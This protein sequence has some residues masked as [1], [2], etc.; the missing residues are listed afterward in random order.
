MPFTSLDPS[1]MGPNPDR[2]VTWVYL[3]GGKVRAFTFL[4]HQALG[5]NNPSTLIVYTPPN[6]DVLMQL[7]QVSST[8]ARLASQIQWSAM[9]STLVLGPCQRWYL[10]VVREQREAA[11]VAVT[12][13]TYLKRYSKPLP[14]S[15]Q[16]ASLGQTAKGSGLLLTVLA[17]RTRDLEGMPVE[18]DPASV[19][20][21]VRLQ[22]AAID[23]LTGE[24]VRLDT[25]RTVETTRQLVDSDAWVTLVT[26]M[27][28]EPGL[29]E[30]RLSV[31]QDDDRGNVFGAPIDPPAAAFAASD[32]VLGSGQGAVQ[33]R[34]DGVMVPVSAFSTYQAGDELPL[35]YE[36][37]GLTVGSEYRTRVS[38]QRLNDSRVVSTVTF[39]D[40]A[41]APTMGL[42]RSLRLND[43]KAV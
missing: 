22:I 6:L 14:A 11:G 41:T 15:I 13:D 39:T 9:G 21:D 5:S 16:F 32:I 18:G 33:W 38:L 24:S 1:L 10:D 42:S 26:A 31:E 12:T 2:N 29:R 35:Y 36:L 28:L 27:H 40:R 17:L 43:L 8:Y 7:S 20:F 37:Y 23:S 25:V 34:R 30:I 3:M 4:G 19:R